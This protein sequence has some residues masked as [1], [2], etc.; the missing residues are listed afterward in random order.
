MLK[1]INSHIRLFYRISRITKFLSLCSTYDLIGNSINIKKNQICD[2]GYV[3][4]IK[5]KL[6]LFIFALY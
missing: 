1:N 2:F 5:D 6:D 4:R 3:I